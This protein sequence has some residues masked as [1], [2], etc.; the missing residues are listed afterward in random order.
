M[1]ANGQIVLASG[2]TLD[3]ETQW[4][5]PLVLSVSDGVDAAGEADTSAD[6]S[7]PV[8]IQVEDTDPTV[9]PTVTFK[10][11][12]HDSDV[13]VTGNP[14]ADGSTYNLRTTLH[15]APEGATLIYDWDEQG[16]HN[17]LWSNRIHTSHY[18]AQGLQAG[19][20]TYTVHIKWPGGGITDSYTITWE[21]P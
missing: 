18:P 6:D 1:H 15:N 14:V 9:H 20:K 2:H 13:A 8:L 17:P 21:A 5:Y 10:L 4:E 11:T 16:W 3:Y 19:P 12:P 7:I